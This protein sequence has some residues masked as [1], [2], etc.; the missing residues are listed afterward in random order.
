M[1]R[2]FEVGT[3]ISYAPVSVVISG[4]GGSRT[5][6]SQFLTASSAGGEHPD[7]ATSTLDPCKDVNRF[8][9]LAKGGNWT[10]ASYDVVFTFTAADVDAGAI[11]SDFLVERS[12]NGSWSVPVPGSAT[13]TS[14][15]ARGL[16][17]FGA[18]IASSTF[19]AGEPGTGSCP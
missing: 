3:G 10:F 4:V 17:T 8:W 19:A 12:S 13:A 2:T 6:G 18:P 7:I 15:Q 14:T 5:D 11:P 9:T 1:V 16:T